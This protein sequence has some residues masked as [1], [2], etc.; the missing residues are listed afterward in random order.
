MIRW[1][2]YVIISI[3]CLEVF[4]LDKSLGG[5]TFLIVSALEY[6]AAKKGIKGLHQANSEA[7]AEWRVNSSRSL[8]ESRSH[9]L[10][11]Q[12]KCQRNNSLGLADESTSPAT[13]TRREDIVSSLV[14][15]VKQKYYKNLDA[16][17]KMIISN[18]LPLVGLA[19][20]VPIL[21][22]IELFWVNQLGDTLAV[23]AQSAANTLYQFSFGLI[24]FLP[25]V[26]ATLV[27]R[28]FAKN[29]LEKTERTIIT[30]LSFGLLASS[31]ISITIFKDP[32]R[33]LG[34]VLKGMKSVIIGCD[35][36]RDFD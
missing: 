27:S 13:R 25:N 5:S 12:E 31:A 20:I 23:S 33:Y 29:D 36:M 28:N 24:S 19:A 2:L 34:A 7:T 6:P 30:A 35:K 11:T 18:T 15:L 22:S 4:F 32:S 3:T 10:D 16:M 1:K 17:D 9:E 8:P 14:N 21:Q 26:T